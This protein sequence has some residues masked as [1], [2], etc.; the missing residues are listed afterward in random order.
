M[1]KLI[2]ALALAKAESSEAEGLN[3]SLRS[4]C[5]D[6]TVEIEILKR[7]EAEETTRNHNLAESLSR[8][9]NDIQALRDQNAA[10]S[11]RFQN[12]KRKPR[13]GWDR[14]DASGRGQR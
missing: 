13:K 7:R 12:I 10:P 1:V 4:P 8:I 9:M 5:D 14:S 2:N 3:I 6:L 11:F